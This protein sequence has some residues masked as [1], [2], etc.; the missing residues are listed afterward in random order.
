MRFDSHTKCVELL[1]RTT[2]LLQAGCK[3]QN[4]ERQMSFLRD[5]W[6]WSW[7]NREEVM[8]RN[9]SS[10]DVDVTFLDDFIDRN[11]S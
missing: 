5:D 7:N 9:I 4:D 1:T 2:S 3:D 10:Q 11:L 8:V 6:T